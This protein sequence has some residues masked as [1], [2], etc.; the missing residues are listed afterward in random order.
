MKRFKQEF[1]NYTTNQQII[2]IYNKNEEERIRLEDFSIDTRCVV[3]DWGVEETRCVVC[4]GLNGKWT[5]GIRWGGVPL[6]VAWIELL[7]GLWLG[8]LVFWGNA[9]HCCPRRYKSSDKSLPSADRKTS[10]LSCLQD[11]VKYKSS[12]SDLSLSVPKKRL[13]VVLGRSLSL[14]VNT[15]C[16]NIVAFQHRFWL[17][18]VQSLSYRW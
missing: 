3:F 14:R 9:W 2:W 11:S 10:L 7:L 12:I 16:G 8:G 13:N 5:K 15:E 17:R 1:W 6:I 4:G 18:G